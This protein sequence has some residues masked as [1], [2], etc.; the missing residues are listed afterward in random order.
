[1]PDRVK[2]I[3]AKIKDFWNKF[4]KTQ[5]ILFVSIF[6]VIIV[7]III[8]AIVFSRENTVLLKQC[9]NASEATEIRTLLEDGNISCTISENFVVRV[10][11]EDYV[12]AKLILGSNNITADGYSLEDAVSGGFSETAANS[13]RKYKAYLESKFSKDLEAI[14]GVKKA[15]VTV[16]FPEAGNTIFTEN[17][18]AS[19]TAELTLTKELSSAQAEAIGLMLA[20]FVGNNNTNKVVVLDSNANLL[21][22][23]G[24]ADGFYS[25]TTASQKVQAQ[26]EN[27][28][29]AKAEQLLLGTKLFSEVIVSPKLSVD[30][31]D[32]EIIDHKYQ[33]PEGS[34]GGLLEHSYVVNS[35]GNIA[36]ASGIAGTESNDNDTSYQIPNADGSS[37][38]YTLTE[39]DWLQNETITTTKQASGK[40]KYDESS[41]SIVAMKYHILHEEDAEAQ[42]LLENMTW[43]QYKAAN[44]E[45]VAIEMPSEFREI[46]SMGTG[47]SIEDVA[48][49]G[50]E[51]Y[52]FYDKETSSPSTFFILQ[53]VLAVLI[54]ALLIFI[55]VRST[56]PVAVEETEPELSVEDM[57][58]ATREHVEDIDLQEKSDTR[59]AIEKLVDENPETVALL[60]RN[61]LNEGW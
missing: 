57:L 61:W 37:S 34:D 25:S 41:V 44:S 42:G 12:E 39:Y 48:I 15:I 9:E 5:K 28:V 1:M 32:V 19:I 59:K 27:A 30:F 11:E 58:A 43:E 21:Y 51:K 52:I 49:I 46:V 36:S 56:R 55:I 10:N 54:A 20:N 16:S 53:I 6:A 31:D 26:Y 45:A 13:E 50:Y 22:Y 4:N 14:D 23:G 35:E 18:D 24:N 2:A 33:A 3:L 38:T 7:T 47:I 17:E 29:V 40:I 8:L 60:L